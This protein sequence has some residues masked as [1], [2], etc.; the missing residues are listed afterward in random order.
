MECQIRYTFFCWTF[1]LHRHATYLKH[2]LRQIRL[3]V[4]GKKQELLLQCIRV[5]S[6]DC[7][8]PLRKDGETV[9]WSESWGRERLQMATFLSYFFFLSWHIYSTNGNFQDL[10]SY[11]RFRQRMR[12]RVRIAQHLFLSTWVSKRVAEAILYDIWDPFHAEALK[13]VKTWQRKKMDRE[14]FRRL[15]LISIYHNDKSKTND[16]DKL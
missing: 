6:P 4:W 13:V 3:L 7:L 5:S 8:I 2:A 11:R 14:K 12:K 9:G 16:K 15:A 1:N 10:S